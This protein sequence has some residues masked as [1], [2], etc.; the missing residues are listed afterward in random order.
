VSSYPG[1]DSGWISVSISTEYNFTHN[2]GTTLTRPLRHS[3]FYAI[4]SGITSFSDNVVDITGYYS[5]INDNIG[6]MLLHR[7]LN[8]CTIRFGNTGVIRFN[9]SFS[10]SDYSGVAGTTFTNGYIRLYLY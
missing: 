3:L 8:L 7:T 1:Y 4:N 6:Y 10:S 2:L 9:N 5:Q